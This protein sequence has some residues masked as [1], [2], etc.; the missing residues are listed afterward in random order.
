MW[1]SAPSGLL[2]CALYAKRALRE[3][4]FRLAECHRAGLAA[5]SPVHNPDQRCRWPEAI[6]RL[7]AN[8]SRQQLYASHLLQV[9][10]ISL[11]VM[12]YCPDGMAEGRIRQQRL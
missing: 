11:L 1:Y 7:P 4:R 6:L 12:R 3:F 5:S 10:E 8:A 2:G 9:R